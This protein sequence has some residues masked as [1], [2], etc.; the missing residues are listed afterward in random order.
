MVERV[1]KSG[2]RDPSGEPFVAALSDTVDFERV[3]K[4][5]YVGGGGNIA[6]IAEDSNTA[7]TFSAVPSGYILPVRVRRILVTG[8]TASNIIGL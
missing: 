1:S 4:A 3:A 5:L 7:V 8:T 2:V 6:L